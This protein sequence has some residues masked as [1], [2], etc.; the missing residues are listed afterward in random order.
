MGESRDT[1]DESLNID[2]SVE[3]EAVKRIKMLKIKP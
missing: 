1:I 3:I 2:L